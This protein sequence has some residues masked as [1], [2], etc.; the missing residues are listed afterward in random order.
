M[1]ILEEI[2]IRKNRL[3]SDSLDIAKKSISSVFVKIAGML[4]AL[5]A[6]VLMGRLLGVGGYGTI[7][8]A[9]RVSTIFLII[10]LF[11]FSDIILKEIAI[12]KIK[13]K[14]FL[15]R[16][17]MYTAIGFSLIF[18]IVIAT[19]IVFLGEYLAIYIFG[20]PTLILPLRIMIIA[21][22]FHTLSRC[23]TS[24]INGFGKI[25]QS[26]LGDQTLSMILVFI[27][28]IIANKYTKVDVQTVAFI[29]LIS[30]IGVSICMGAYWFRLLPIAKK[31]SRFVFQKQLLRPASHLLLSSASSLISMSAASIIL[32]I[33]VSVREVGL[34]NI[35][36]RLALLTIVFLQI[37]NSALAPKIASFYH[38]GKKK[39]LEKLLS[40]VTFVLV[41]I[42]VISLLIFV[43][44]G[45]YI[46]S[47]WG[48]GF[49]E[50]YYYL[51]L[52]AFGQFVNIS[53]G[54]VS[55]ILVMTGNEKIVGRISI[56]FMILSIL[57]NILLI[58]FYGGI[59]A[60]LATGLIIAGENLTRLIY[61]KS[62][63]G[64][65]IFNY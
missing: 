12:A 23:F 57:L 51:I 47:L 60:A 26:S 35:S 29:Y 30:R 48:D 1:K 40:N 44:G 21:M 45:K 4:A 63:T 32:G 41:F 53:T 24:G 56:I 25:W 34:Y 31:N 15:I 54:A 49:K 55:T 2:L 58:Y 3:S 5:G 13:N 61:V 22:I 9:N 27:L 37:T 62:K 28:L 6:S 36:T 46:L 59:G 50:A 38:L 11:G 39:E 14:I 33:M 8:L 52:L 18:S 20:T 16:N 19:I 64:I 17:Y 43:F 42:G 65:N 7:E 10:S